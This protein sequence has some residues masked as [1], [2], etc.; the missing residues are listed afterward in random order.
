MMKSGD[1]SKLI[2]SYRQ[3][4]T[5]VT[6]PSD[7]AAIPIKLCTFELIPDEFIFDFMDDAFEEF[8]GVNKDGTPIWQNKK[9]TP[10]AILGL[11]TLDEEARDLPTDSK[12]F[13]CMGMLFIDITGDI[14]RWDGDHY[15]T[16]F[17]NDCDKIG[18]IE[19]L[20]NWISFK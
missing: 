15:V 18:T 17:S 3:A 11:Y 8:L 10:I 13:Q 5:E 20:Y 9:I 1:I 14:R 19:D 12:D 6:F 7:G 4:Y 2:D 16:D